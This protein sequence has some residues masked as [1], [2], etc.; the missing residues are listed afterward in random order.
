MVHYCII[1]NLFY[2]GK[3]ERWPS[4]LHSFPP[5]HFFPTRNLFPDQLNKHLDINHPTI[6]HYQ[7]YPRPL[8]AETHH[9][10]PSLVHH[11]HQQH[12]HYRFTVISPG[13]TLRLRIRV[14]THA[15][16]QPCVFQGRREEP[17]RAGDRKQRN[18]EGGEPQRGAER[19]GTADNRRLWNTP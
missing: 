15:F 8:R 5:D 13:R 16:P 18:P 7:H 17:P 6:Q 14:D 2:L 4:R 10:S 3:K 19:E 1:P 11:H 12:H 9:D